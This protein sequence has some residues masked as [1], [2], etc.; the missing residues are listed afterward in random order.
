[1]T[2]PSLRFV[3]PGSPPHAVLLLAAYVLPRSARAADSGFLSAE[4]TATHFF[5]P[6]QHNVV[7]VAGTFAD[8]AAFQANFLQNF[9]QTGGI[10]RWGY[11]TSAVFEET[12]AISP[13][14]TSAASSTG[15]RPRAAAITPFSAG[16]PG[17]TSAAGSAAPSTR[18]SS[19]TSP[20]PIPVT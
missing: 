13:S 8:G 10:E 3:A 16:S 9:N 12:P 11:P 4:I 5:D 18:A 14:T 20:I 6:L 15:N 7:D 1:M 19:C 2:I 17:T